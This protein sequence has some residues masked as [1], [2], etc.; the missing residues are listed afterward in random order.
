MALSEN[1]E[2]GF[3]LLSRSVFESDVWCRKPP[4]Y[5]KLWVYLIGQAAH[6]DRKYRGYELKRGQLFRSSKDLEEQISYLVGYRAAGKSAST[7]KRVLKFLRDTGRITYT[8]APRGYLITVLHYDQ[9]QTPANYER[10]GERTARE[11]RTSRSRSSINKK[12]NTV[13]NDKDVELR[14]RIVK[15]LFT[16]EIGNPEGYV[17]SIEQKAP[18]S[19]IRKAFNDWNRGCGVTNASTFY[20]R[21]ME[22]AAREQKQDAKA[23]AYIADFLTHAAD[24]ES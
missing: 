6:A 8:S 4:E 13:K 18:W 9:Y 22:Y 21:C 1:F 11:P 5:A 2:R 15:H 7:V 17:R 19:A 10:T 14:E 20:Q 3:F 24:A 16:C 12:G 23:T